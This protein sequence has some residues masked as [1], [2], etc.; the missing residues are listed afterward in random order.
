MSVDESLMMWKGRLSWK[1]YIP[2][3]HARFGIKSFKLSEAKSGYVWNFIIY[4]GYDTAFDE[5]LN[6]G[7]YIWLKSSSPNGSST[8]SG[9][10]CNHG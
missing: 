2:S 9:T 3:K 6:N 10:L 4:I 8:E 5:S 7:P 1:I